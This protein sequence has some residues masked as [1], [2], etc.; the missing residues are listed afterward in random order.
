MSTMSNLRSKVIRLAHQ[1]PELRAALL[2]LLKQGNDQL[3]AIDQSEHP[4]VIQY[5]L[6][7]LMKG[8]SFSSA[9]KRS[10]RT[11]DGSTNIFVGSGHLISIDPKKLADALWET[12]VKQVLK[13]IESFKKNKERI[14]LLAVAD[15]F[16]LKGKEIDLLEKKVVQQL[17]RPLVQID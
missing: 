2:P 6:S 17:G 11:F 1:K 13:N 7:C 12:F 9:L 15:L 8:Q 14:A 5:T 3:S 16:N 10:M 4:T